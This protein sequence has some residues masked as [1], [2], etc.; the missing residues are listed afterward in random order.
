MHIAFVEIANFRKLKCIRVDFDKK[1]TIFVGANNSG[2]TSAMVA[3][4]YFLHKRGGFSIN[5]F[6]LCHRAKIRDIGQAWIAN[7]KSAQPDAPQLPEWDDVL[8]FLDVWLEA[9]QSDLHHVSHLLPTLDWAGGNL[10]VRLRLQPLEITELYRDFIEANEAARSARDGAKGT[11]GKAV[12]VTLWPIDIV[13]FLSKRLSKYLK[14]AAYILDP[15]KASPPENGMA[16]PQPLAGDAMPLDDS[17]PFAGLIQIDEIP[18]QR[19][20]GE[21][22]SGGETENVSSLRG[23]RKLASQFRDYFSKHLDPTDKPVAADILALK[24]IEDA[25]KAYDERLKTSFAGPLQEMEGLG[26]PGVTDPRVKI[27]TR[28]RPTD[29]LDHEAAV[30]YEVSAMQGVAAAVLPEDY[31]GLGYQNLISM[32][33]RLMSFRDA[34]MRVG[35][36]RNSEENRLSGNI[37]PLHLVLIEEPEAHLHAQV[38]QVFVRKAYSLLRKS[39]LLGTGSQFA[40][41]LIISTHSSHVAHE[42]EFSCLRYFKRLPA[43]YPSTAQPVAT[44]PISTVINLTEAFG[45]ES[46]TSRF[47]KRYLRA[48]HCDLFFADAAIFIEGSAERMLLPHFVK[49]EFEYLNECYITWLEVGG[50]HAH[51]LEP[52][53]EHLGLLTLIVTDLDAGDPANKRKATRPL[54]GKGLST[55]NTT[56]RT[57]LPKESEIDKLL[58]L[59]DD[60]KISDKEPL[61][62][63]CVAYQV[64]LEIELGGTKAKVSPYTFEDAIVLENLATVRTMSGTGLTGKFAAL[65]KSETDAEELANKLFDAIDT[66]K[67]AEFALDLL[68]LKEGPTALRCPTYIANGLRW[69]QKKLKD[70]RAEVLAPLVSTAQ[71]INDA[72]SGITAA[73]AAT[74]PEGL[75][76]QTLAPG[77]GETAP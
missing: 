35:K 67:K 2:K 7:S 21:A 63:V 60:K 12:E 31:N 3:L 73:S 15:S 53:I 29:G 10:G 13:D 33:F 14:I 24:A 17:D 56:L 65:A 51:R 49:N 54:M 16:K 70:N 64:P 48:T 36:A 40:T 19:G 6:T 8:P 11:D 9:S 1:T 42:A 58:D 59:P 41:Q 4:R 18:A 46:E 76:E 72:V 77:N 30:Q 68:E 69:L 23:A 39:E 22:Q 25:Q 5:D 27:S 50:S 26:Y 71:A 20:F 52:L 37:A 34:W 43:G 45:D 47:A 32:V 66:A 55:N 74:S 38:Q 44:V 61:F 62:A 57:W 75:G 28:L